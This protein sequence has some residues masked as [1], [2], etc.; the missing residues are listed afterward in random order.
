MRHNKG[1]F[2]NRA[3]E[4]LL[5]LRTALCERN[6]GFIQERLKYY[7]EAAIKFRRG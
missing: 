2:K 4:H 3:K 5:L 6:T 7:Q 1:Q